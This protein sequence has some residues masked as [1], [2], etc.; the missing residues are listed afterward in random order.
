MWSYYTSVLKFR[1]QLLLEVKG[2]LYLYSDFPYGA[3]A[4][5][6]KGFS[7]F[8]LYNISSVRKV[9]LK[10][11]DW[12]RW[13]LDILWPVGHIWSMGSPS[14]ACV[15]SSV[16]SRG[17]GV[18]IIGISVLMG[19]G[20]VSVQC[21]QPRHQGVNNE[22]LSSDGRGLPEQT[23]FLLWFLWKINCPPLA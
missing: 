17:W 11:S 19:W 9:G 7:S 6:Y 10:N 18:S 1:Y 20:S 8:C 14:L 2:Y 13:N 16:S 15:I 3:H 22:G 21:W 23:M 4:S 5:S 12:S